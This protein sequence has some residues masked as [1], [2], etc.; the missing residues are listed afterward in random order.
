MTAQHPNHH[1][2][3][4]LPPCLLF[5]SLVPIIIMPPPQRHHKLKHL[6]PQ[7]PSFHPVFHR[8]EIVL[9]DGA[10]RGVLHR[11]IVADERFACL[12]VAQ[13]S[14]SQAEAGG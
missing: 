6:A 7:N 3:L 2:L 11:F 9:R 4:R 10:S 14:G 1:L 5:S 13:A 8:S 12:G